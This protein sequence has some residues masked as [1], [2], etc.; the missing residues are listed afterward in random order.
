MVFREKQKIDGDES[1][2]LRGYI[3]SHDLL[4]FYCSY[5]L[6]GLQKV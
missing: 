4:D 6:S 1:F 5:A 3:L 2:L